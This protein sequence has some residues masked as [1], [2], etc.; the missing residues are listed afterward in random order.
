MTGSCALDPHGHARRVLEYDKVLAAV[1]GEAR[2]AAGR[3]RI[4]A[5]LPSDDAS[6]V[7]AEHATVSEARRALDE[8]FGPWSFDGVREGV[9]QHLQDATRGDAALDAGALRDV[10]DALEA[11]TRLRRTLD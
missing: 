11:A 5:L 4:E 1:A 6:R 10:A 3:A 9:D 8:G 7:A 2:T